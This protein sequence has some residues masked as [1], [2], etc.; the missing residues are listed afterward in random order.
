[1]TM[2]RTNLPASITLPCGTV[3]CHK[4]SYLPGVGY[5]R[6]VLINKIKKLGGKYRCVEVLARR[7]RGREELHYK[8]YRPT[9]WILTDLSGIDFAAAKELLPSRD[10]IPIS[11]R[12]GPDGTPG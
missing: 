3:L 11:S 2:L 9:T 12:G 8:P 5:S 6:R 10:V 1:M 4:I 7:L